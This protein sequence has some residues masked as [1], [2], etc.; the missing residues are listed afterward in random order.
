ML[1]AV[2]VSTMAYQ[3]ARH[4]QIVQLLQDSIF[5]YRVSLQ[6]DADVPACPELD[7][8]VSRWRF[9]SVMPECMPPFFPGDSID[10][11]TARLARKRD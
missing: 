7:L 9:D 5:E 4:G 11:S 1:L 8:K 10:V 2:T 6:I 3:F